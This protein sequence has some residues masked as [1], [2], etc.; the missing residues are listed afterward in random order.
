MIVAA[1]SAVVYAGV[2][3][4]TTRHWHRTPPIA[5]RAVAVVMGAAWPLMLAILFAMLVGLALR[6]GA[7][8]QRR[9]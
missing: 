9:I 7:S 6:G 3:V 1:L 2:A 8:A 5:P 4:A